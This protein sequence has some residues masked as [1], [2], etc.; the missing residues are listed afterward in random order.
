MGVLCDI[1]DPNGWSPVKGDDC[2]VQHQ[3]A[4]GY[5]PLPIMEEAGLPLKMREQLARLN[6]HGATFEE[7]AN[8]IEKEL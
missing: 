8:L 6:D 1:L 5:P 7:L 4:Q 3:G 2:V